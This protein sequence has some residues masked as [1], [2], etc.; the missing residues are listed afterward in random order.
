[1]LWLFSMYLNLC[2]NYGVVLLKSMNITKSSNVQINVHFWT[3]RRWPLMAH[4]KFTV[5]TFY[6]EKIFV[7][8][9]LK[10]RIFSCFKISSANGVLD[11]YWKVAALLLFD[12]NGRMSLPLLF[13][14]LI[15]SFSSREK[16]PEN[17]LNKRFQP[18]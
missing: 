3:G 16:W 10:N 4:K 7:T 8:I 6:L 5:T 11:I 18:I 14:S 2:A 1:M 13:I 17:E 9:T 12:I 15:Y